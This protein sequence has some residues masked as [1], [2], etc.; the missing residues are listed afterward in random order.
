MSRFANMSRLKERNGSKRFRNMLHSSRNP[1]HRTRVRR[2]EDSQVPHT[3]EASLFWVLYAA[4]TKTCLRELGQVKNLLHNRAKAQGQNTKSLQPLC[5]PVYFIVS[6]FQ[7]TVV[8][9]P[10]TVLVQTCR[11]DV[12]SPVPSTYFPICTPC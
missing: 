10:M 12:S 1:K 5:E 4:E 2:R 9:S 7:E 11:D 8:V 3:A 6:E